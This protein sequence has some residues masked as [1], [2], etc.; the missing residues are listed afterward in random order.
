LDFSKVDLPDG[1]TERE[2]VDVALD[3]ENGSQGLPTRYR[4]QNFEDS[5]TGTWKVLLARE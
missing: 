1:V 2:L 3:R 5:G 4:V